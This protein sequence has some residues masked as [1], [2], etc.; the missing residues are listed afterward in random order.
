MSVQEETS[1]NNLTKTFF[2]QCFYRLMIINQLNLN[3]I[4]QR[5]KSI[6]VAVL[7]CS[8]WICAHGPQQATLFLF[9]HF[10]CAC[11]KLQLL[12]TTGNLKVPSLN[13]H[14]CHVVRMEPKEPECFL[15]IF[16]SPCVQVFL[17]WNAV[18]MWPLVDWRFS[19]TNVLQ[20]KRQS[21]WLSR[22]TLDW[23]K[24]VPWLFFV[25]SSFLLFV[26]LLVR[27]RDV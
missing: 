18:F 26:A 12:L 13:S 17:D 24:Y 8:N 11:Q 9:I 22:S 25:F 10:L 23:S 14:R 1:T 2:R 20:R 27:W 15:F 5:W 3:T 4:R 16:F 6:I 19:Y 21:H 7:P